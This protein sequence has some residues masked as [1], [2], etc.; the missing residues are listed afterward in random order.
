MLPDITFSLLL[1]YF[2]INK[3][4]ND[5]Q[6]QAVIAFLDIKRPRISVIFFLHV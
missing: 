6:K 1:T 4:V 2:M 3:R 5:A